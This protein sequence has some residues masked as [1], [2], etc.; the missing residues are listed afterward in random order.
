MLRAGVTAAF[1]LSGAGV[2]ADSRL[3]M[4]AYTQHSTP[5]YHTDSGCRSWS[6][7]ARLSYQQRV[8]ESLW[9]DIGAGRNSNGGR[10]L[11]GGLLWEPVKFRQLSLGGFLGA[12]TGYRCDTCQTLTPAA[13]V[14]GSLQLSGLDGF[15]VQVLWIPP[16]FQGL[17]VGQ[18]RIGW[19]W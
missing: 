17:G 14:S 16:V 2:H 8:G 7:P 18:V 9:L 5:C 19:G 13:G 4:D 10:G 3:L 11:S 6:Q 1:L 15:T 12:G